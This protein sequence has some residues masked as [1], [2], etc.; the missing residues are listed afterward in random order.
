M[1]ITNFFKKGKGDV[2]DLTRTPAKK[3]KA[4]QLDTDTSP[5]PKKKFVSLATFK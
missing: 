1:N 5:S 2:V 4:D 3:S